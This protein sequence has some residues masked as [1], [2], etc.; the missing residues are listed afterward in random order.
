MFKTIFNLVLG[1]ITSI[2]TENFRLKPL[3]VL[4]INVNKKPD[5]STEYDGVVEIKC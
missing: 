5:I 2:I 3:A 4:T 1:L